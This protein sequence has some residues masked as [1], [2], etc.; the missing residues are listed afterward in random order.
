LGAIQVKPFGLVFI[1]DEIEDL[2]NGFFLRMSGES[3]YG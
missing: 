3:E 1:L 2:F